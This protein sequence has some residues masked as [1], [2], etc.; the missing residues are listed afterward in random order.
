M[1]RHAI[2]A[3]LCA[4]VLSAG[5]QEGAPAGAPVWP[6]SYRSRLEALALMQTLNAEILA[7]RSATRSL[8]SWCAA[9]RLADEP[10]IVAD[11]IRDVAKVPTAEQLARLQVR[12]A[13]EVRYRRVRLRCGTRV[14]SEADNWYVPAR[15]TS[16]MNHTLETTDA[17]F[18]RVVAP[19]EPYRRTFEA[20]LLWAPLPEGWD[21]GT[22]VEPDG[23][24]LT[25]PGALFEHRALLYTADHVPFSEVVE[26][27]QRD[28]LGVP[29]SIAQSARD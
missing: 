4:A 17:P 27:Y 20:R 18:G 7:S 12:D 8:E 19:L 29:P 1:I 16:E 6:D 24:T 5:A 2:A 21:R 15:L 9:R 3:A 10:R 25:I 28:I 14:M 23:G 11:R 26:T 13:G 22:R